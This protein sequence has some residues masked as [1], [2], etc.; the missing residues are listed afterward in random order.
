VDDTLKHEGDKPTIGL[1]LCQGK[2]RVLAKYVLRGID[3]P[4]GASDYDLTRALPERLKSSLPTIEET[5]M[6]LQ[7]D[8]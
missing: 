5:E 4:I 8:V 1:I 7:R 2:D 3:K 6:E